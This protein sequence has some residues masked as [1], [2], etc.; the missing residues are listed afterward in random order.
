[1]A[2]GYKMYTET[3]IEYEKYYEIN[4]LYLTGNI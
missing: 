3:E 1:M 4:A 2:F